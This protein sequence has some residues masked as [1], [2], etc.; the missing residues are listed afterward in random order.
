MTPSIIGG[1]PAN[2]TSINLLSEIP[3]EK[4]N[5]VLAIHLATL[6]PE[7]DMPAPML[8]EGRYVMTK[9]GGIIVGDVSKWFSEAHRRLVSTFEEVIT[10]ECR[11]NFY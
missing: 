10:E 7:K 8:L 6:S 4:T 11:K 3:I 1:I 9:R 2:A 5:D